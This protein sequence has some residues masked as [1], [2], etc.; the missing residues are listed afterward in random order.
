[1]I[2]VDDG[3][4]DETKSVV[5]KFNGNVRYVYQENAGVSAARNKGLKLINGNLISFIDAD[6]IWV[7]NKLE[8]QLE[9]LRKNPEY[10][11]IIGLLYRVSVEKTDAVKN[12]EVEDGEHA[13]SLGS[14]LLKKRYLRRLASLMKR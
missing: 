14:V 7:E 2:V 12:M 8:I 3:S 11:I 4:T 9:L 5:K 13:A 6:D 10:D 1:M